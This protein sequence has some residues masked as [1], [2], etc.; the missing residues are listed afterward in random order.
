MERRL[1]FTIGHSNR[2]IGEFVDILEKHAISVLLDIRAMPGSRANPQFNADA[3]GAALKKR[4]IQYINMEALGGFRKPMKDSKNTY[5]RNPSFRGFADYMQ[6]SEFDAAIEK[7]GKIAALN[8]TVLMCA[9]VLPWRCHR[10]LIADALCLRGFK[11]IHI[12]NSTVL[13]EHSLTAGANV[14]RRTKLY[15]PTKAVEK[16]QQS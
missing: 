9:E 7:A 1:I 13:K 11:V 15:Y 6:T 8:R 3:L 12:L 14:Y 16:S 10:Y 4:G 5:W 2:S